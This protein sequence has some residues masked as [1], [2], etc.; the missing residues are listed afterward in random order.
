MSSVMED[1]VVNGK[2]QMKAFYVAPSV[3]M[4]SVVVEDGF[5]TSQFNN[6]SGMTE[7]MNVVNWN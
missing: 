4:K 7:Q 3:K 1:T 2:A 5:G 6:H